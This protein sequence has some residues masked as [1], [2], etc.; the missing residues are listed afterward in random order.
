MPG[1]IPLSMASIK[2]Q[3]SQNPQKTSESNFANAARQRWQRLAE[4]LQTDVTAFNSSRGGADFSQTSVNEFRVSNLITGV[5]LII[6]ADF[7][8]RIIRYNYA[9]VNDKSAGAPEGGMLSMRQSQGGSV[10][11]YSA[12]EQLT[13]EETRE[14]LLAPLFPEEKPSQ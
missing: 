5:Q 3:T 6:N 14:V 13:S 1:F 10:E 7:D 9:Q 12:D 2:D 8:A 11:F 4:E